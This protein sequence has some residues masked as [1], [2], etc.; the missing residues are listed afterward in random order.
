MN[1]FDYVR[2]ASLAEAIARQAIAMQEDELVLLQRLRAGESL[3]EISGAT[4]KIEA[5]N[6]AASAG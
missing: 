1:R 4:R 3:P 2:P 5:R 6:A